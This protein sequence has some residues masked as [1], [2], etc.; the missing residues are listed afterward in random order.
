MKIRIYHYDEEGNEQLDDYADAI[1]IHMDRYHNE[2]TVIADNR[3]TKYKLTQ[4]F[5]IQDAWYL[6]TE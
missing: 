4:V 6:D 1:G 5:G 2:L 3:T